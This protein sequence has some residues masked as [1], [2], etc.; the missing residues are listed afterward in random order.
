M[1]IYIE[2][3]EGAEL[4]KSPHVTVGSLSL[5]SVGW[6]S[7]LEIRTGAEMAVLR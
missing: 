4:K 6:A 7:Q 3:E 5:K 2:R 1:Y